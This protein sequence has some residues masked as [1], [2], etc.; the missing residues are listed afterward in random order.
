MGDGDVKMEKLATAAL[1]YALP[2]GAIATHPASPRDSARLMVVGRGGGVP[3]H[4]LVRDL[5]EILRPG[6]LLVRNV[7]KV[8]PARLRGVRV[9]TGGAMEGLYLGEEAGA[10][11]G[12]KEGGRVWRAMVK[13]R[14]L[15]PG[16][17]IALLDRRG[18]DSGVRMRLIER[19]GESP[20]D[21]NEASW[22]AEVEAGGALAGAGTLAIL[23]AVG[24]TPLPPYIRAAR[25]QAHEEVNEE[26][27]RSAYQTVFADA[28]DAASV[29]AP[30]AGLHFTPELDARLRERGAAFAQVTLHVGMGTFKPV[31]TATVEEHAMH[32]EWCAAPAETGRAMLEA[33]ARGGRVVAVGT[34]TARTLES[35]ESAEEIASGAGE[36]ARG[37]RLTR[38]LIT[39]G[40]R[41][42]NVDALMTNFHLPR[43]TLMA[44]VAAFLG[45][46]GVG[47]LKG[48]YGE[49]V[50]RGYQ[51]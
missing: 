38:I 14:R 27:D 39:P 7:T 1:E 19:A 32:E 50:A 13:L 16:V 48:L 41:F 18:D 8:I 20:D 42:R 47:R 25:K 3:K 29:A 34:T 31:E 24:L 6:D 51:F 46:D 45:E 43:S 12:G 21:P 15:K 10:R 17:E 35:F 36:A 28:R 9:D 22:R 26:R 37:G 5:P 4:L 2:E 23:E 49:A 11:E 40:Y 33:R 44:M 30:T